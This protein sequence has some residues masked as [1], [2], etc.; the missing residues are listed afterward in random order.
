M[1]GV[2]VVMCSECTIRPALPHA[3][4]CDKCSLRAVRCAEKTARTVRCLARLP[5]PPMRMVR[6]AAP[7][8]QPVQSLPS[9]HAQP[10]QQQVPPLDWPTVL[11]AVV[12][13]LG[14]A[15]AAV[16]ALWFSTP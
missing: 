12:C 1:D 9:S 6:V 7:E 15:V 3:L 13:V 2:G 16:A 14:M 8:A 5:T 10:A 11:L 4:T